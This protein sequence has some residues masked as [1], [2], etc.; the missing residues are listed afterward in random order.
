MKEFNELPDEV[1]CFVCLKTLKDY[2]TLAMEIVCKDSILV[3]PVAVC[4]EDLE[5]IINHPDA[6]R[7][8]VQSR[9]NAIVKNDTDS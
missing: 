9:L 5:W 2:R 7:A 6:G 1:K 3:Y 4:T 8:L